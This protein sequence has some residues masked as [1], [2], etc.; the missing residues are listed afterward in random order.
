MSLVAETGVRK[1]SV[2]MRKLKLRELNAENSVNLRSMPGKNPLQNKERSKTLAEAEGGNG[3]PSRPFFW[4]FKITNMS[5]KSVVIPWELGT[6]P[7]TIRRA[8]KNLAIADLDAKVAWAV[9]CGG[10]ALLELYHGLK[11]VPSRR[12]ANGVRDWPGNPEPGKVVEYQLIVKQK[13]H[14]DEVDSDDSTSE[15]S[16][17]ESD[18]EDADEAEEHVQEDDGEL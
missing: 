7:D 17:V 1:K 14:D 10:T 12:T 6:E 9:E 3:Q 2:S 18:D 15:G 13:E 11:R 8:I 5:G 16:D 4:I